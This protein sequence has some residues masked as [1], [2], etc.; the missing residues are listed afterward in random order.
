MKS[1]Q[2]SISSELGRRP[3]VMAQAKMSSSVP[4]L[5]HALDQGGILDPEKAD[6]ASVESAPEVGVVFLRQLARG[7]Q[8]NLV[9]HAGEVGDPASLS[10]GAAQVGHVHGREG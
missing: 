3:C 1:F 9:E 6:G 10:V 2:I 4:P 7:V 8:A 5:L